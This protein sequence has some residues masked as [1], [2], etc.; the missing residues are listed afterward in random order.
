MSV[1]AIDYTDKDFASLRAAMLRLA[2]QRLPEW[3]DRSPSDLVMVLIDLFA[4]CGDI[5]AYYQDRIASEMFPETATERA[6]L[7]DLL[8]LIGYEFTPATPA[9]ADLRLT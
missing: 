6:G 4:Y 5:V 9:R 2:T 3:T 8:R 7:V 1:P